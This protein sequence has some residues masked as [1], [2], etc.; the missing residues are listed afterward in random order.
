MHNIMQIIAVE[1]VG[2][3]NRRDQH[4]SAIYSFRG[5]L[6][7]ALTHVRTFSFDFWH[8]N[9]NESTEVPNARLCS[10][11]IY[12]SMHYVYSTNTSTCTLHEHDQQV[13]TP[14]LPEYAHAQSNYRIALMVKGRHVEWTRYTWLTTSSIQSRLC[15]LETTKNW[16]K[17]C[18]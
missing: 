7:T 18:W 15:G 5:P 11:H 3:T 12:K 17:A 13:H 16:R 9:Y 10:M 4:K 14:A 6:W 2:M 1:C 8:L